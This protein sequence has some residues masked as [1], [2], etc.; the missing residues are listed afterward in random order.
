MYGINTLLILFW[1]VYFSFVGYNWTYEAWKKITQ[2][3]DVR[4]QIFD[5]VVFLILLRTFV[6]SLF[7]KNKLLLLFIEDLPKIVYSVIQ[8]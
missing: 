8:Y 2:N 1:K 5:M 6:N 4:I 3:Q 7:K